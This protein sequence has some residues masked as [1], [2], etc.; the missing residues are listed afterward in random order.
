MSNTGLSSQEYTFDCSARYNVAYTNPPS[1]ILPPPIRV[2]LASFRMTAIDVPASRGTSRIL[3]D[4]FMRKYRVTFDVKERR[5]QL[6]VEFGDDPPGGLFTL[7][8]HQ[9]PARLTSAKIAKITP[10]IWNKVR[11]RTSA[12]PHDVSAAPPLDH[13]LQRYSRVHLHRGETRSGKAECE[14]TWCGWRTFPNMAAKGE[15]EDTRCFCRTSPGSLPSFQQGC[16]MALL[17]LGLTRKP[18]GRVRL[19]M[20]R[21][22]T[23]VT[24][25]K[26]KDAHATSRTSPQFTNEE[27]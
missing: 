3:V 5:G 14:A 1:R 12:E 20:T 16:R 7:S 24:R 13:C 2:E 9:K 17:L 27:F 15:C 23:P 11:E 25:G 21:A 22:Q 4:V 19:S 8:A 10:P 26:T 6:A 18:R